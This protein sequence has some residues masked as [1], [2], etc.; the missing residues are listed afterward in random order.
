MSKKE[1]ALK[2]GLA[3][4]TA[5]KRR[6]LVQRNIAESLGI[7]VAAVGMWES[8]KNSPSFDNLRRTAALLRVDASALSEGEIVYLDDEGL[9]DAEV[10]SDL[11]PPPSGPMDV[12][13]LGVSYGGDDGDFS[14]NGEVQG[15]VRRPPG[16]ASLKNV[17]ALHVLSDSMVPRYDPGEV[18]YCGGR[19]AVPGDHVVI[20]MFPE[21]EGH[22][23]KAFIKKLVQRTAKEI[24]VEQY[25]PAKR[26]RYDRYA[27]KH[28]WRVIPLKE[29]LGF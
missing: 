17:F 4:K 26:I 14:F 10:I 19:E 29:L 13:L 27:V 7:E 8:G 3:I 11:S 24:I 1:N 9:A 28:L 6:G 5:R 15:F 2:I 18:I 12:Q 16:V 25:N 22:V 23:G 21:E 20:E